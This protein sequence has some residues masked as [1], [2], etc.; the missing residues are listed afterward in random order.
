MYACMHVCMHVYIPPHR[1]IFH[2]Q[3]IL[4]SF[5]ILLS[6]VSQQKTEI[7]KEELDSCVGMRPQQPSTINY[8]ESRTDTRIYIPD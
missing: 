3:N 2:S 8:V 7:K 5:F 1:R 6:R 4:L